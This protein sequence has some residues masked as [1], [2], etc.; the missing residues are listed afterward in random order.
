MSTLPQ[1]TLA[2]L[3]HLPV[4]L[5][6]EFPEVPPAKIESLVHSVAGRLL[7]EAHFYD[8]V[9][10]LAHRRVRETLRAELQPSTVS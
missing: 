1:S 3:K 6:H 8:Y 7:D 4:T 9:P 10:L 2:N 5:E